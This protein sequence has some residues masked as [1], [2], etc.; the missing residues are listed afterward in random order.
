MANESYANAVMN[1]DA[2]NAA[3]TGERVL[4]EFAADSDDRDFQRAYYDNPR[5]RE[6]LN[7]VALDAAYHDLSEPPAEDEPELDE[8]RSTSAARPDGVGLRR[9]G[10]RVV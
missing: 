3:L 1:S 7:R 8:R 5:L 9:R 10:L 6:A 4:R 2:E